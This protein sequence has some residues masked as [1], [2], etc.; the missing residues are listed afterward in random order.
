M[1]DAWGPGNTQ[2]QSNA[3]KEDKNCENVFSSNFCEPNILEMPVL[4][5]DYSSRLGTY[6]YEPFIL[7]AYL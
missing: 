6:K 2:Q 3:T 1:A 5:D 7:K 4:S